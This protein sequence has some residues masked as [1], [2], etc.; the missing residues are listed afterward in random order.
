MK[1]EIFSSPAP[2]DGQQGNRQYS[3]RFAPEAL[4]L[5]VMQI[6]RKSDNSPLSSV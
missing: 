5:E 2:T 3:I 6:G 4:S 1:V